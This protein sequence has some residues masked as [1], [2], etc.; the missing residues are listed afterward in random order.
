MKVEVK[1][2]DVTKRELKFEI[3][4]ERVAQKLNEV[5][6]DLGKVAKIKGFRPGKA[7]RHVLEAQH[8]DLAREETVKKLIPEVYR[9]GIEQEKLEPLDMPEI[10]DVDFKDGI[11]RFTAKLDIKPDVKVK[12]YKGIK[13]KRK[14]NQVTDEEIDK[15]LE[16]IKKGQ[17]KDKEIV[18]DDAW[19]RGSGYPNLEE[20]KEFLVRQ[21]EM[22]KDRQNRMDV[23]N[24]IVEA[25]LKNASVTAPASLVK[26]QLEHRISETKHRLRQQGLPEEQLNQQDEQL[27]KELEKPVEKDVQ[28]Y[29]VLDKIAELEKITVNEGESLSHK[30]M[31]FLL[32]EADWS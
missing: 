19:A 29:L 21:M 6:S 5:Y 24:Q 20:F 17:G 4:R 3:P 23:E 2:I 15:T 18:L 1:K 8:S 10:L 31:E 11:I 7:P 9:E 12:D 27:R 32:K 22:D 13:V 26:R 14:S 16:Y 28:V 30:V 25:L